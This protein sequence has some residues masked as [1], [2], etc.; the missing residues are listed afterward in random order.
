MKEEGTRAVLDVMILSP[1]DNQVTGGGRWLSSLQLGEMSVGKDVPGAEV[2]VLC[3]RVADRAAGA[4][5]AV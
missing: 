2:S 4:S 3:T 5:G 1:S